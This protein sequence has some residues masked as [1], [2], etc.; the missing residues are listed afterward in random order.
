MAVTKIRRTY[1][2][3]PDVVA[4]VKRMVDEGKIAPSQDA[5]VE[6]ALRRYA[7]LV[8]DRAH[9][10]R[11]AQAASDPSFKAEMKALLR[12]FESDDRGAWDQE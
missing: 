10:E 9:G 11:W 7:R 8:R 3:S 2:L 4:A 1:N 12:E 5:L 6:R